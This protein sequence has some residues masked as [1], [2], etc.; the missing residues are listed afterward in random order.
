MAVV[1]AGVF[2]SGLLARPHP[3]DDAK[4][5]YADARR[6]LVERAQ[7]IA[8]SMRAARRTLPAAAIAFPLA[9]PA[10]VSVCLGARS[11]EQMQRNV[12]LYGEL[13]APDLWSELKARG[14]LREEAPV[15]AGVPAERQSHGRAV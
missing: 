6:A 4:Y 12:A 13:I 8:A 5:D 10:V 7:A 15:P 3:P 1:A 9:H 11:A 14:L 2:N